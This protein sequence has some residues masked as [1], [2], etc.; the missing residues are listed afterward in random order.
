MPPRPPALPG[1]PPRRGCL[2]RILAAAGLLVLAFLALKSWRAFVDRRLD[3]SWRQS[4]GGASF[5]ERYPDVQDN[6]TVRD[7]EK[8]GAAIG[9][10][11]AP[12]DTP[13]H[14]HPA[15]GAARRFGAIQERLKSFLSTNE[16]STDGTFKPP[17]PELVAFLESVRPGLD[18]IRTR[19][20]E[21][22][23]P[24]WARNL[25]AGLETRLPNYL[26][27][28][29][30]QRLLLLDAG[31]RLR[32]GHANEAT[33][34][35]ETS[36]RLNEAMADNNPTLACQLIALAVIR[37]QQ[38]VLRS[39]P[40]APAG[41]PERLRRLDLQSRI[42]RAFRCVAF[43]IHRTASLDRPAPGGWP[44]WAEPFPH[45]MLWDSIRRVAPVIEDLPKRD[46]RVFDAKAFERE[47]KAAI[48][49]WQITARSVFPDYWDTW[50]RSAH[51]ELEAE[52][53]ALILEER[54]RLAAGGPPLP[55]HQRPSR[56]KG[57]SWIYEDL[58]GATVLHL[59][60][61]MVYQDQRPVPLRFTVRRGASVG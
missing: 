26:G 37:L 61:D 30:L 31:Q 32:A 20:A 36:G 8:L 9:I 43:S 19:L 10:D 42:L 52:L 5:L 47:Q 33:E 49:R 38:P 7:L 21:G 12:A 1:R 4:L 39:F 59:D 14:V 17:S 29:M 11:M 45:W 28:L 44:G 16:L 25:S 22:P 50:P 51:S 60:G 46:V 23:P 53:T 6:A 18:A 41:W 24:V 58:P 34:I 48:P 27:P 35:L 3:A 57:L 56:V 55:F 54:E 15:P 2:R 13:G 40:R